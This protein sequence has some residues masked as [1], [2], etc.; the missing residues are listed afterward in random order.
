MQRFGALTGSDALEDTLNRF[1]FASSIALKNENCSRRLEFWTCVRLSGD[2]L[3]PTT[4]RGV[5]IDLRAA[6]AWVIIS[7]SHNASDQQPTLIS[8]VVET[9]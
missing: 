6:D 9:R 1:F 3:N 2:S 4:C 7:T 8:T 5:Q